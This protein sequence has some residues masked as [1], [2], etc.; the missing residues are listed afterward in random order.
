MGGPFVV[1]V[2]AF[3]PL[4]F[5]VTAEGWDVLDSDVDATAFPASFSFSFPFFFVA[6]FPFFSLALYI[7]PFQVDDMKSPLAV[8]S[9][10]APP[11]FA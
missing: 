10:G 11:S 3:D 9:S 1:G 7:P 4:V 8:A 2:A 5:L 6:A